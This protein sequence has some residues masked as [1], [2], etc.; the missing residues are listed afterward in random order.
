MKASEPTEF[1]TTRELAALLRIKE[2]KVYELVSSGQIPVTRATGKLLFERGAINAWMDSN[3]SGKPASTT[4]SASWPERPLIFAGSHDPLLEWALRES[5][6][7]LATYFDGSL[8]GLSR[9]SAHQ[10][11]AFALHVRDA[12]TGAW[13]TPL[14]EQTFAGQ[15]IVLVEFAWRER[16][17][18]IRSED[19][20]KIRGLKDLRGRR[21]VPRQAAAG[22]HVLFSQLLEA[23]GIAPSAYQTCEPA[24]TETEAGLAVLEGKGDVAFG[25]ACL[26]K[27]LRLSF[28]PIISERFDF[29]LEQRHWFEAEMQR[30]TQFC[31]TDAFHRKADELG[32]Y[33][34]EG[35][36]TVHFNSW[37][38]KEHNATSETSIGDKA[39]AARAE[40]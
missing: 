33:T 34:V 24:R 4:T 8:D 5:N 30:F 37:P 2:R 39:T 35:F 25:L 23:E 7:G 1:L 27:Q 16:G 10:A 9:F 36:G 32:G 28:V 29:L 40:P 38:D 14:I 31:G 17:L 22:T 13:N 11:I 18:L 3:S 15:P 6:C 19:R 26:A 12:S 21:V 20:D